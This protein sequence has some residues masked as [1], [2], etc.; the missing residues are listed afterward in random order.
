MTDIKY[1]EITLSDHTTVWA[2][3]SLG[4]LRE[5][6]NHYRLSGEKIKRARVVG[7]DVARCHTAWD[8]FRMEYHIHH[9]EGI[10]G[11]INLGQKISTL[12]D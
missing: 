4:E 3:T 5:S 1:A 6:L 2:Y 8:Q 12:C 7:E 9:S 11:A 10:K